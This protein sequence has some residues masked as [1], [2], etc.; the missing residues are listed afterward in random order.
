MS[1]RDDNRVEYNYENELEWVS[2]N[3]AQ[4]SLVHTTID[5]KLIALTKVVENLQ[6]RIETLEAIEEKNWDENINS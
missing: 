6:S 2:H 1:L 4:N 3:T 5:D